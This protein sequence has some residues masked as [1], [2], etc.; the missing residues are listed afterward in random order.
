VETGIGSIQAGSWIKE[1]LQREVWGVE[2]SVKRS[3]W[4]WDCCAG[5]YLAYSLGRHLVSNLFT[6][7][8]ITAQNF[9]KFYNNKGC[10]ACVYLF[11]MQR[12]NN[13]AMFHACARKGSA[14]SVKKSAK[15]IKN[16]I[17]TLHVPGASLQAQLTVRDNTKRCKT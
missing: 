5:F 14:A 7:P 9:G 2:N 13:G 17:L 11:L 12:Q 6:F 15:K 4:V 8:L 16:H 10:A 1:S 3:V